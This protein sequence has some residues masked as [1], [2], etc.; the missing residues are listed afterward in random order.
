VL[1]IEL[2]DRKCAESDGHANWRIRMAKKVRGGINAF[3]DEAKQRKDGLS[4]PGDISHQGNRDLPRP[5]GSRSGRDPQHVALSST[6][7]R[8]PI[9]SQ[10]CGYTF[11]R[12]ARCQ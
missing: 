4:S 12:T 2:A 7:G 10:K 5:H 1:L 6:R 8:K 3:E 9:F 11:T